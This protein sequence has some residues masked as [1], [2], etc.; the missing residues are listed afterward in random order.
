[1]LWAD[2]NDDR[3]IA[4][5]RRMPG[6]VAAAFQISDTTDKSDNKQGGSNSGAIQ[7]ECCYTADTEQTTGNYER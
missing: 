5:N 2:N 1:M 4:D 6:V 7:D 3:V